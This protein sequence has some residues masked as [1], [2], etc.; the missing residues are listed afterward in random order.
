M[1]FNAALLEKYYSSCALSIFEYS[2]KSFKLFRSIL[3]KFSLKKFSY[4]PKILAAIKT[5]KY[6][7]DEFL[8][9]TGDFA[10]TTFE[11]KNKI[12]YWLKC[13]RN[14]LAL[15]YITSFN[16]GKETVEE[17]NYLYHKWERDYENYFRD[18]DYIVRLKILKEL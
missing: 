16:E 3:S 18:F 5:E 15:N 1:D 2:I 9:I 10:I 13:N 17:Y 4:N 7:L 11:K 12:E 8:R 6:G 14:G